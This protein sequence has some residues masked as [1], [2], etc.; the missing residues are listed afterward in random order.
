MS[1]N[2]LWVTNRTK[3]PLYLRR[4]FALREK[5]T[6]AELLACGLGQFNAYLNGRRVGNGWD[7]GGREILDPHP[8]VRASAQS[9]FD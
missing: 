1:L 5:P 8:H 9:P 2:K 3:Q 6:S 4:R 7:E